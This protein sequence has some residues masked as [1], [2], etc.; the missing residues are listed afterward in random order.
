LP[1][2]FY[3]RNGERIASNHG[4]W[5]SYG[6]YGLC[7]KDVQ[8]M[9]RAAGCRDGRKYRM[10]LGAGVA[11]K[12]G[13]SLTWFA[14]YVRGL[15]WVRKNARHLCLSRNAIAAL[16]R[17]SWRCRWAA[18]AEVKPDNRPLR[19]RDLNW[20]AVRQMQDAVKH[21]N[22]RLAASF[23]G[24]RGMAEQLGRDCYV[25]REIVPLLCPSYPT[26]EMSKARLLARGMR[27]VD[28]AQGELTA[29]EAHAWLMSSGRD[30]GEWY[31]GHHQLPRHRSIR[32]LKWLLALKRAKRWDTLT[33]T[34]T[35]FVG[36]QAVNYTAMDVLDEIQPEDIHTGKDSVTDV[37]ARASERGGKEYME[38]N[39][40]NFEVLAEIPAWCRKLPTFVRVLNTPAA[41]V[42]EG[43]QQNHCVGTYVNVVRSKTSVVL[44]IQTRH[45]HTTAEIA[46]DGSVVRQHRSYKNRLPA[47]RN[48]VWLTAFMNRLGRAIQKAA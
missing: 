33:K 43:E 21:G 27:P 23:L 31:A 6:K 45:G 1:V 26:I 44:A 12:K 20:Q 10:Q 35:Q 29:A 17:L 7:A 42:A 28:I 24:C 46:Y 5:D 30:L 41:L 4:G 48:D 13:D 47:T 25:E 15:R 2:T 11:A 38:R 37:L 36:G 18:L 8:D 3:A 34:R 19:I 22:D 16:G 40:E 39:R 14:N 9:W 32:V